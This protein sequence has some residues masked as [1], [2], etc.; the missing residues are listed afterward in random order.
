V[1]AGESALKLLAQAGETAAKAAAGDLAAAMVRGLDA[2]TTVS[3]ML[4][5]AS[6]AGIRV[7]ATGGLGGVHPGTRW[8][9]SADLDALSRFPALVVCTGAK[10][11]LDLNATLEALETRGVPVVG[12]QTERFPRFY[13]GGSSPHPLRHRV[14]SPAEAAALAR[15][16]WEVLGQRTAVV[17]AV[18]P[19]PGRLIDPDAFARAAREAQAAARAAGVMGSALTPY[20]LGALTHRLGPSATEANVRLLTH[21]AA[22]AG[23]VAVA[24]ATP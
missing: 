13:L 14:D 8:D 9:I 12:Y 15:T 18:A 1:G 22:L 20:M 16:H 6:L 11:L 24:L 10:A 3:G 5:L 23:E 19:P 7:M 4:V 17:L 2:G 21:N